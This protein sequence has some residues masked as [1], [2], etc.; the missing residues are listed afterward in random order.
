[1][2]LVSQPGAKYFDV[3]VDNQKKSVFRTFDANL[4]YFPALFGW[5]S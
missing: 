4:F 3:F 1:M 2:F 5:A